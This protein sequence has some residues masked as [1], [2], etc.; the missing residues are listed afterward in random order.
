MKKSYLPIFYIFTVL[1]SFCTFI[2][3]AQNSVKNFNIRS[4]NSVSV[5]SGIDLFI[6]QGNE[7]RLHIE[8]S[9]DLL[10]NV[11]V[12]QEGRHVTIKYKSNT[13]NWN[14]MFKNQGIKAYITIKDL[15]TLKSS[16]G[17]DV[18]S[19]GQLTLAN[20]DI[21]SSGGS[22]VKLN[23]KSTNISV[24]SSGGSDVDLTGSTT[25]FTASASGGS[26]IN[27]R[28]LNSVYAKI[29]ASG[30][31]DVTLSVSK[32]LDANATGGSDIHYKGNPE[33]RKN[34]SKS[35]D[36]TRIN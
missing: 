20:L 22:D 8:S 5:A 19:V 14:R 36:V 30:G 26:D 9:N 33:V 21:T 28:N 27:A 23:I 29:T 13:N 16:G 24:S 31:S 3:N 25:N 2:S 15:N 18:E 10:K 6:K 17:S 34:N 12:I 32:A 11:E 7:E 4:I 35:G 1:F